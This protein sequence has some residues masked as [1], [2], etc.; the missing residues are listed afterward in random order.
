[1]LSRKTLEEKSTAVWHPDAESTLCI[2]PWCHLLFC[3]NYELNR[4]LLGRLHH[5]VTQWPP[6]HNARPTIQVT[7]PTN[8]HTVLAWRVLQS[9]LLLRVHMLKPWLRKLSQNKK[10]AS[11]LL[12][13]LQRQSRKCVGV[14]PANLWLL[15]RSTPR[16]V[17]G[18]SPYRKAKLLDPC[19]RDTR[20]VLGITSRRNKPHQQLVSIFHVSFYVGS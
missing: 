15:L 11:R 20:V 5:L 4:A 13:V 9:T 3:S 8:E 18:G 17:Y 16:L 10:C 14:H 6:R 2:R 19:E 1:M 7:H 12:Q